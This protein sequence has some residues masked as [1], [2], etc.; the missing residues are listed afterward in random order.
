LTKQGNA[1]KVYLIFEEL[2]KEVRPPHT[3]MK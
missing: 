2:I 3:G 1:I